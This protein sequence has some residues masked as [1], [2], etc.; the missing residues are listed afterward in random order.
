MKYFYVLSALL[1][2][3]VAVAKK[4]GHHHHKHEAHVHGSAT[5]NIAFDQLNG[6]IEFKSPAESI[7][8][9]EHE[10]KSANEILLKDKAIENFEKNISSMIQFDANS[11]CQISKESIGIVTKQSQKDSVKMKK[12][13]HSDFI[14]IFNVKCENDL[15]NSNLK[16][17]LSTVKKLH[18]IEIIILLDDLQKQFK[19][20]NKEFDLFLK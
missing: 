14:A 15:L 20:K 17:N 13:E 1:M 5:L 10:A 3:N 4:H 11:K 9:F 16:L 8:G 12:G 7:V 18:N 6:K 19:I 2:S